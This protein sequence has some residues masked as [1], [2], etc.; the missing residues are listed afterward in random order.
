MGLKIVYGKSGTGKSEYIFNEIKDI[1]K[2][3]E[4]IYIITPEQFSFTAEKKLL[5]SVK[6]GSVINAE[7]LSFERMA[8]RVMNEA[9]L[10]N[11]THLSESGK[12]MLIYSILDDNKQKLKF[13]GKSDKNVE[14]VSKTF[15]E[16]KKHNISCETLSS[17]KENIESL[18]L[19]TK[20]DDISLL[21]KAYENKI[22]NNYID[23]NDVLTLLRNELE[24]TDIFK[25]TVIYI[26][27]FQ[28]FTPQEYGIIESLLRQAKQVTITMCTD[29]VIV[30][31][32]PETDIYYANKVTIS[33]LLNLV[34]DE[35]V[36]TIYL[37]DSYRFKSKE[38]KHLE[39]NLYS[40]PYNVYK[41][42][43]KDI[44][45]FLAL[46]QYEEIE[47]VSKEIIKLVRDNK[48]RYN[49]IAIITKNLDEYSSLIKAIFE[50]YNIP[51]F[52]DEKKDLNQNVLVK[53]I[54]SLIDIFAKN[55]S[56]DSVMNY[57]KTGFLDLTDEEI[58][59][60]E[61][62]TLS[63]GIKQS[64]WYK[65]E[66]KYG[67][68]DDDFIKKM[69]ELRKKIIFPILNFKNKLS[70]TKTYREITTELY[71]FIIDNNISNKLIEKAENLRLMGNIELADEY[72]ACFD[73]LINLFDE[74]VMCFDDEKVTFEKYENVLMCGLNSSS[75]G[76]IPQSIDQ[77]IVGDVDRSRSHKIKAMFIIGLNDGMFPG[78]NKN[79]GF[80]DD[81]DRDILKEND[82]EL[83]KG[84]G[85]RMYD[86]NFNIY[87]AM[88][89]AE[90]K[91]LLSYSAVDSENKALRAS[92][93]IAKLH[94]I[95]QNLKEQ[96]DLLESKVSI[97]TKKIIFDDL[98]INL[99]NFIDGRQIDEIWFKIFKLYSENE[100]WKDELYNAIKALKFTNIPK[101]LDT[102]LLEK[103]YGDTLKT[104][105]SRLEQYK[106]CPFSFYLKY[107]LKLSE[108]SL[109]QIQSLDTG[110]FM[111]EVIDEFFTMVSENNIK[112]REISDEQIEKIISKIIEDK[113]L[114]KKNYIF[115]S[116]A[117]YRL[118]A[119]KL[120]E[121]VL[122]SMKYIIGTIRAGEFDVF[123]TEI[124]FNKNAKYP[125]IKLDLENGK[126]VEIVGKIDRVDVASSGKEK[127]VRIIDYKS[128]VKD[129]DLNKV[130]AGL[131]IQLLKYMDAITEIENFLPAGFF[132]FNLIEPI[133][134]ARKN[135]T[136]EEIE[137]KIKKLFKMNGLVLADVNVVRMMDSSLKSGYSS[138]I[139][140]YINNDNELSKKSSNAISNEEFKKLQKNIKTT[141][142]Q[143]SKEILGGNIDL[144][145]YSKKKKTPCDYCTYKSI[146][147]FDTSMCGNDFNYIK[148]EK[149]EEILAKM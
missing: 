65:E 145:P 124:E 89:T 54:I 72:I 133:I 103:L 47:H 61:N 104:S 18:Y 28:G 63:T 77:V 120:K 32:Q 23:E 146:C 119:K 99:R 50:K 21:Y 9:G 14:L 87:K 121:L 73:I 88:T 49:E 66:F 36:K 102:V 46:N 68:F 5:E 59:N 134:K 84:M 69:N 141:I 25:N 83:A 109:F 62:Y 43:V 39:Q 41:E 19:K 135:A 42:E 40:I 82:M 129:I 112:I 90:E 27:E 92:I 130:V 30:D 93:L 123:G 108:K 106:S 67:D 96:S 70:G 86:D 91:L 116:T 38:L 115:Q 74:I 136:D 55:W 100:E 31:R 131:Q 15:T 51:V 37:K 80:L 2:K 114:L 137:D 113:L 139:P 3:D 12:N 81:K 57:V 101:K 10:A 140:A 22:K 107:T 125:P 142:K 76:K 8:Y 126:H 20:L 105:I 44:S 118:L 24:N 35:E 98:I 85:E 95:F 117:K 16:L 53:F 13:L 132:Y 64:K 7:V 147:Q 148:E 58:Y 45:L 138:V 60:F 34:Q 17:T 149:K 128:S 29:C 33:K 1:I 11:T 71:N 111:H 56:Y 4:K 6:T 75:L 122:K 26:D 143:I 94:K 79:E 78:I 52:I 127:Y 144:K 48:Y 97:T 110:T